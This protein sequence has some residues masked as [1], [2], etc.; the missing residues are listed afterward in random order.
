M[1]SSLTLCSG[2]LFRQYTYKGLQFSE[3]K[4]QSKVV[5]WSFFRGSK[6]TGL[7]G[8]TMALVNSSA[9]AI[10]IPVKRSEEI[11]LGYQVAWGWMAG[12][13]MALTVP[14]HP[15]G[16]KPTDHRKEGEETA[17]QRPWNVFCSYKIF[18]MAD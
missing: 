13:G 15:P 12:S 9:L 14:F 5:T 7:Q 6:Q 4:H 2:V 1:D 18:L 10:S 16:R 8:C 3:V 17:A 11:W